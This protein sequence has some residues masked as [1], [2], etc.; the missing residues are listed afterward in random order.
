ML[1]G[2]IFLWD[3][4]HRFS[5]RLLVAF[6][7]LVGS[8]LAGVCAGLFL[9]TY[10]LYSLERGKKQTHV[11]GSHAFFVE[12]EL[13][14]PLDWTHPENVTCQISLGEQNIFR[15]HARLDT[16]AVKPAW[17]LHNVGVELLYAMQK[18]THADTLGF[19]EHIHYIVLFCSAALLGNTV[20]RW[21]ITQ[22][23][24]DL[25]RGPLGPFLNTLCRSV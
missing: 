9:P 21:N 23:S 6:L 11:H 22:S 5:T 3:S 4:G 10:A 7:A 2:A 20:R 12:V 17:Q 1:L 24:N 8:F 14:L 19:L 18:L 25:H 13:I 15:S 16:G